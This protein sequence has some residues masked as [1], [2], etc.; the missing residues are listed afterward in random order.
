MIGVNRHASVW[1]RTIFAVPF[2]MIIIGPRV[3]RRKRNTHP[4]VSVKMKPQHR[5]GAVIFD[6]RIT[7][8]RA[9]CWGACCN[10]R[11]ENFGNFFKS[12]LVTERVSLKLG[13]SQDPKELLPFEK[14]PL[15]RLPFAAAAFSHVLCCS[16]DSRERLSRWREMK[17]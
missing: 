11:G 4:E 17:Y 8:V 13:G 14:F 2:K 16:A 6:L 9:T 5:R 1:R 10:E 12:F 3:T 7:G 15:Y